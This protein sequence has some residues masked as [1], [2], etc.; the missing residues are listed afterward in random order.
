[1]AIMLMMA[2][3]RGMLLV[4]EMVAASAVNM[5]MATGMAMPTAMGARTSFPSDGNVGGPYMVAAE[6]PQ[7]VNRISPNWLQSCHGRA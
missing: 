6:D 1:M 7:C 3:V 2:C 5:D 4:V